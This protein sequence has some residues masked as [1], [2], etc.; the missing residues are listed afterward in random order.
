MSIHASKGQKKTLLWALQ[1]DTAFNKSKQ[2]LV[3]A[4]MLNH[5]RAD[6]LIALTVD[7]SNVAIGTVLEH[8]I[9]NA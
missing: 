8:Q 2:A 9:S 7:A 6:V 1:M 4:K 3:D 5:P